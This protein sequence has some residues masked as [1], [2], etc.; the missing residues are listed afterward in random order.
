MPVAGTTIYFAEVIGGGQGAANSRLVQPEP[1]AVSQNTQVNFGTDTTVR[2]YRLVPERFDVAGPTGGDPAASPPTTAGDV[3]WNIP[4]SQMDRPSGRPRKMFAGTVAAN[5]RLIWTDLDA[6]ASAGTW[7]MRAHLYKRTAGA[8]F[9]LLGTGEVSIAAADVGLV[10][11]NYTINVSVAETLFQPGETLHAEYWARGR[12]TVTGIALRFRTGLD[13]PDVSLVLPGAGLVHVTELAGYTRDAAGA[14]LPGATVKV[15]NQASDTKA[16]EQTSAAD[17]RYSWV[18]DSTDTNT[19]YVVAYKA[20]AP[21][22]HGVSD[23]GLVAA[24]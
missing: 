13:T 10:L 12:G 22:I 6:L 1:T 8:T 4:A 3:G 17:G 23:R 20:D 5:I 18:R 11:K 15:F 9:T 2:W 24:E 21:E 19:Y 14:A 16:N 7:K